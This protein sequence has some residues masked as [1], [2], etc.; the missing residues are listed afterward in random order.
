VFIIFQFTEI[1][2]TK[3]YNEDNMTGIIHP[4]ADTVLAQNGKYS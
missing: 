2:F 1:L 4:E 3:Y